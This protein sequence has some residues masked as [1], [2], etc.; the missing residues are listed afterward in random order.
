[1]MIQKVYVFG[2]WFYYFQSPTGEPI[3]RINIYVFIYTWNSLNEKINKT[4]NI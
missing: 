3:K 2:I 4:Q 1:M